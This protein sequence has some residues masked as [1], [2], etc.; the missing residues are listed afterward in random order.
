MKNDDAAWQTFV[1]T[2]IAL[3]D[4]AVVK[5]AYKCDA[6]F[7]DLDIAPVTVVNSTRYWFGLF[8]H[9]RGGLW[10]GMLEIELPVTVDSN[11]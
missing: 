7:V 10:K 8:S 5:A 11:T 3:I 6:Y 1:M 9:R 4:P 2:N